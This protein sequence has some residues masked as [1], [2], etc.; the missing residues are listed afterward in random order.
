MEV[1]DRLDDREAETTRHSRI[2]PRRVRPV[3][4]LEDLTDV[5]RRDTGARILNRD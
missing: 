3:E 2:S 4:A 5:A 1:H